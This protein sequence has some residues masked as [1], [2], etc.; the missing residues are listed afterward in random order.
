MSP[1]ARR[2]FHQVESGPVMEELH[3]WL[4]QQFAERRVEPNSALGGA[5]SYMLGLTHFFSLGD[6]VAVEH[7]LQFRPA[8]P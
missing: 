6:E 8:A 5:I 4:G 2:H 3:I 1:M 7:G